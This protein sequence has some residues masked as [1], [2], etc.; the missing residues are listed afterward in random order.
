MNRDQLIKKLS[1]VLTK[2][3]TVQLAMN[4][5]CKPVDLIELSL[6]PRSEIAFRASWILEQ[7]VHFRWEDL[8]P[9]LPDL[10][11][12]YLRQENRSCQRHFTKIMMYLT[13]PESS[14]YIKSLIDSNQDKIIE[15]TFEWLIDPETPVAVKV[16]CM[17][18]LL[19]LRSGSEWIPDELRSQVQYLLKDGSA[20]VQSRGKRILKKLKP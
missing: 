1:Q 8:V 3:K 6:F 20:A 14:Q 10:I 13:H 17:D 16:N 11:S 12:V 9:S 2:K 4:K 7:L 15:R 18:I 5:A 19:N